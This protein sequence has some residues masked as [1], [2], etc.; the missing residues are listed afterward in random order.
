[1]LRDAI[2]LLSTNEILHSRLQGLLI[3]LR[4]RAQRAPVP[5]EEIMNESDR[6]LEEAIKLR[7]RCDVLTT[8]KKLPQ[9]CLTR[10]KTTGAVIAI[11]RGEIGFYAIQTQLTPEEFNQR[12]GISP[13]QVEAMENGSLL[14]WEVPAADPDIVKRL[15]EQRE[16]GEAST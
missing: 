13:D 14:G 6:T 10:S 8:L 2:V 15:R 7:T 3:A 9:M 4:A 11:R 1:L 12:R 5:L 16:A